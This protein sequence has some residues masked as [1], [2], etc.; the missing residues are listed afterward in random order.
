M[1]ISSDSHPCQIV[2]FTVSVSSDCEVPHSNIVH[3]R[4]HTREHTQMRNFWGNVR[5]VQNWFA[6]LQ[7]KRVKIPYFHNLIMTVS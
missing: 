4:E 6:T 2:Q 7:L 5:S 3:T 1:K